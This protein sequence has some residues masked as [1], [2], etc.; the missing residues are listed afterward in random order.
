MGK[1]IV[2]EF[3]TLD[4][5]VQDPGGAEEFERGGWNA[6][7]W[8]D[9]LDE[10]KSSELFAADGLLLGRVT[11]DGFAKAWPDMSH[12]TGPYADRMNGF[13]KY[14]VSNSLT[15]ADLTWN[16]SHLVTGD[17]RD[18]VRALRDERDLELLVFGS[19]ALVRQLMQ[20]GLVE[21]LNLQ[22]HP[23]VVGRGQRLFDDAA[24][25]PIGLTLVDAKAL[26][27]GVVLL[28]YTAQLAS[29]SSS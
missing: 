4:G 12:E 26:A 1:I 16:N 3:M 15:Q 5:V 29:P 18:A 11:Y 6:P 25:A 24:P 7:Y 14:V 21:Q 9:E 13:L 8:S 23:V 28:T 10:F 17:L 2:S 19:G 22:V 27:S 20:L